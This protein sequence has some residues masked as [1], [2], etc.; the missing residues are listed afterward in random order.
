MEKQEAIKGLN[1]AIRDGLNQWAD[2]ALEAEYRQWAEDLNYF[3]RDLMNVCYLFMHVSSNIGI[4]SGRVNLENTEEFGE[5]I[6][7]LVIDMTGIDPHHVFD[8]MKSTPQSNC[9]TKNEGKHGKE[10][11]TPSSGDGNLSE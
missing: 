4:K 6:R 2:I 9:G 7:Q 11:E 10:Q 5:R 3:P 8:D 1:Q